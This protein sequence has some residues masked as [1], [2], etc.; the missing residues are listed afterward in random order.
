MLKAK[1]YV[2]CSYSIINGEERGKMAKGDRV[3]LG[4]S[5]C[6]SFGIVIAS[7]VKRS[8][9]SELVTCFD[10]IPERRR[11]YSERFECD[12]EESFK[13]IV[14]RDDIDGV[15][16]VAP[17]NVHAEQAVLAAEH[18]KH[19]FVIKPIAN[20]LA[21]GKRMI[22]ACDKAKVVLMV[23][24]PKRRQA[25]SRKAKEL[26][27]QGALGKLIMVEANASSRQGFELTPDQ[28]RWRGD[29]SGCP[30]GALM[31]IGV[32]DADLFNYLLGPIDTVFSFFNKLYIPAEVE[33]VTTT[34]FRFKSGMLGYLGANFA[35]PR[36][37]WMHIYGTDANLRWMVS[38]IDYDFDELHEVATRARPTS[39]MV[40]FEKGKGERE[41]PFTPVD[42]HL[43]EME[44]YARCIRTGNR[45]ETT[46]QVG[47]ASLSLIR[48]AID[49]AR[50]G[51]PVKIQV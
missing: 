9:S 32:H 16:L 17:N 15:L 41:I 22:E 10:I 36:T 20:T 48:A 27:S 46:G 45:P 33:D 5:G 26:L 12:Q 11:K 51:K 18:G 43:E 25:E 19:V 7:A 4:L 49:S 3:R 8:W 39:R 23:G 34:V 35:S 28:F 6:G 21:D 44:E 1:L 24:H 13:D 30:A 38:H 50:T 47:L 14:E 2:F 42:G 29:D 37:N 31:T 40:L